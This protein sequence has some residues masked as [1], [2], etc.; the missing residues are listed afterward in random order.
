MKTTNAQEL[1]EELENLIIAA[2]AADRDAREF[3]LDLPADDEH[4][5]E[6]MELSKLVWKYN[7]FGINQF[8]ELVEVLKKYE[9]SKEV[10]E[11]KTE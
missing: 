2:K 9:T 5:E 1:I 3:I 4:E 10:K 11:T 8:K 7:F 6:Y